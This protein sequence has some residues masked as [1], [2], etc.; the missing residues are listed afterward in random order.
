MRTVEFDDV[1]VD[2]ERAE[3]CRGRQMVHP[4]RVFP[5][6]QSL[7]ERRNTRAKFFENDWLRQKLNAQNPKHIQTVRGKGYRFTV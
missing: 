2:F 1:E 7:R 4:D 5:C 3:V 6:E